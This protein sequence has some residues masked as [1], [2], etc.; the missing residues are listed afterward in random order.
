[1]IIVIF[2]SYFTWLKLFIWAKRPTEPNEST[3][4]ES[5]NWTESN[6]STHWKDKILT[7]VGCT[8]SWKSAAQ[9]K[10]T[11]D[12]LTHW[13][14][15]KTQI[16]TER[17]SESIKHQQ[18]QIRSFSSWTWIYVLVQWFLRLVPGLFGHMTLLWQIKPATT[19]LLADLLKLE[20]VNP[21]SNKHNCGF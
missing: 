14:A 7:T 12:T 11:W 5:Y 8:E 18:N 16:M 10:V 1:M 21:G 3:L 17:F 2:I 9:N 15:E 4:N 19:R 13:T 6:D 20:S